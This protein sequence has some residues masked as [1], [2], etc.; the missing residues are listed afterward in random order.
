M[1]YSFNFQNQSVQSI[2]DQFANTG[3]PEVRR[4]SSMPS[5]FS[6]RPMDDT[7]P[8]IYELFSLPMGPSTTDLMVV[9]T[10]L[11][12]GN[13]YGEKFHTKGHF[14]TDPDGPEYVLVLSGRGIL[15]RGLRDSTLEESPMEP[16][17]HILVPSGQAH[18]VINID[19]EPLLFISVC[20]AGVGHDY[21]SVSPLGWVR[22][23]SP[24]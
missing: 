2:I 22:T 18:R 14:H 19:N 9:L 17:T 13:I 16:G 11:H 4:W 1:D 5:Y 12:A 24:L 10:V 23:G 7:D 15:E 20:S 8:V 3:D 21:A 6:Q